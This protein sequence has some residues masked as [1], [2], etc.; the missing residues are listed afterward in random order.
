MKA[1]ILPKSGTIDNIKLR[2]IEKP[3][4]KNGEILVKV[5]YCGV[6]HLDLLIISGKRQT[7]GFP[8]VLGSEIAGI[9]TDTN[10]KVAVY[11]WTFC[12]AC[13][14]CKSGCENICDKGGAIGRTRQGG[15]AEYTSVPK[16]NLVKIPDNIDSKLICA[17]T[18]SACTALHMIKRVDIPDKA[19]VLINGATGGVGTAAIQI[20]K[21]K[22]CKI[23]ARTTHKE[24]AKTLKNLGADTVLINEYPQSVPYIIDAM[25]GNVWSESIERLSKNGTIVFCATTLEEQGVVNIGRAFARQLNILGSYGGTIEDLKEVIDFVRKGVIKPV[26]DSVYKLEDVPEALKKLNEQKAFGKILI[27]CNA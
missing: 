22:K 18:L 8:L 21:N 14:Q 7:S 3:V 12:G 25:G 23:I 4:S 17:S 26:I 27:K 9:R 6:N 16:K 15:F 24:K 10:E 1:I 5:D 2:E 11:P 20:L 13:E 19:T